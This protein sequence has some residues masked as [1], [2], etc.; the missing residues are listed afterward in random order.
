MSLN[1]GG[2]ESFP[3]I[4]VNKVKDDFEV[5]ITIPDEKHASEDIRVEGK[6]EGVKNAVKVLKER[7]AELVSRK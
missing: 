5:Q 1:F 3:S 4:S 7:A 6:K 2:V